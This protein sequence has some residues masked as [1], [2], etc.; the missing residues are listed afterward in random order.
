MIVD[1]FHGQFKSQIRCPDCN[2]VST[3]YEPYFQLCV[4]IPEFKSLQFE[5]FFLPADI[6]HRRVENTITL[7]S[8]TPIKKVRKII[9]SHFGIHP[10]SFELAMIQ[11]DRI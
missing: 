1:L 3:K 7:K 8:N 4:P 9:A 6:S 11:E 2:R 5:Y 10:S